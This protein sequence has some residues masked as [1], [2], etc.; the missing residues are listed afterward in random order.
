MGRSGLFPPAARLVTVR[1]SGDDLSNLASLPEVEREV[2]A[3]AVD[4]RRA[5]FADA[6]WCARRALAELGARPDTA[7][8]KGPGGMP[9]WPDGY[10]GSLTH[11]RGVRA[12]VVAPASHLASVGLDAEAAEPVEKAVLDQVALPAEQRRIGELVRGGCPCAGT[13]LFSAKEATYKCWYPLARRWLGFADA[14]IDLRADGT[15]ASRILVRPTPVAVIRGRW[16]LREGYVFTSA[17]VE[18]LR[19]G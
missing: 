8:P 19:G 13:V 6:R 17:W 12:A 3:R 11:T 14:E 5:E 7:I 16:A 2:V 15:F 1:S 9:V 10:V 4:K 18:R